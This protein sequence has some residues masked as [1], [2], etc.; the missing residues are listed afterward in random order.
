MP[1]SQLNGLASYLQ[2]CASDLHSLDRLPHNT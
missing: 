1:L 2:W